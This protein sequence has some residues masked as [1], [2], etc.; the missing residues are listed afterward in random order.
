VTRN[1]EWSVGRIVIRH[2]GC[3]IRVSPARCKLSY[4]YDLLGNPLSRSDGNT[5]LSESFSYD[6]LNRLTAETV[7]LSPTPLAKSYL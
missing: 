4:S 2:L 3:A 7:N 6:A 1:P 5:N